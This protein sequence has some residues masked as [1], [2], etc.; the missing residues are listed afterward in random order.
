MKIKF[1]TL[2]NIELSEHFKK[3]SDDQKEAIR[4]V[5]SVLPFR[6]NNY[7]VD[8]LINWD[9]IPNDPIFQ[10]TFMQKG[11]L[12]KENYEKVKNTIYNK[13]STQ[14]DIASTI[15]NIRRELNPHPAGQLSQNTPTRNNTTVEGVQ[16][17]YKE[18]VLVFPSAGQMCHAYCTF[19]FRWP[20]FIGDKDLKF[21]TDNDM[22]YL[23]YLKENKGVTDVL[24]TGGDPMI[25]NTKMIKKY[26]EP[27]LSEEYSHITNIRIGSKS[28]SYWPK[29]FTEDRD[30]A[31]LLEFFIKVNQSGKKL[32]FM[33]H[34]NHPNEMKTK[35]FISAVKDIQS[36]GTIIR[37]QAPLL[38]HI[39]DNSEAWSTMWKRQVQLGIIPYYMFIERDTGPKEYFSVPLSKA[40]EIYQKA[41]QNVSGLARTVRGPSMSAMPGKV[42]ID[43]ITTIN[44]EK[45][46]VLNLLQARNSN[47]VKRPFFAK[48]NREA[49]W[50]SDL[51]PFDSNDKPFF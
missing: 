12:S 41:I 9:D 25:M 32:A 14:A 13:S 23:N 6:V 31:E 17:K 29:R 3:L 35:D 24:F 37:S 1:Y 11:M 16:H 40:Y 27:L 19:C 38:K 10:L 47:S 7:V 18:T 34:I 42:C 28:L 46:F 8:N 33:A 45:V 2:K 5:G 51:E 21:S 30:A 36:T 22:Q 50:L 20:Q 49:T 39:N 15:F 4:V 48:F 26:I 43:G 44:G